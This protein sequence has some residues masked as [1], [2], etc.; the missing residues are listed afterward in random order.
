MSKPSRRASRRNRTRRTRSSAQQ[1]SVAVVTYPASIPGGVSLRKDVELVRAAILYADEVQLVSLG[2]VTLAGVLQLA[3]G[4]GTELLALLAS[5]DDATVE[6][7][8]GG[9]LPAGWRE[10][11]QAMP[12]L[13]SGP[14]L[15]ALG[16]G[17]EKR[18]FL[19]GMASSADQMR[20]T[21]ERMLRESGGEELLLGFDAGLVRLSASGFADD[22][23]DTDATLQRWLDLLKNLLS[24]T[25]SRLL[26][27]DQVAEL[28]RAMIAEGL[29]EPTD[30]VLKHASEAAV[31][32]GLVARLPAFPQA[33]LD[34]LLDLRRDLQDP[35]VRYRSAVTRLAADLRSRTYEA[36]TASELDDLWARE[37][38]PVLVELDESYAEHS[39]VREIARQLGT[40]LKTL[41]GAGAGIYV[42]LDKL[43][44]IS[45]WVGAAAAVAAPVAE[46]SARGAIASSRSRREASRHELFYLY[47]LDRHLG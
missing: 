8:G 12:A 39:L 16:L 15:D 26:F 17:A 25:R 47:E 44:T 14:V 3:S 29:V 32:S 28:V 27:D 22:D 6:A 23:G 19:E 4:D 45:Q 9:T 37:I 20:E 21:A 33:P 7:L 43:T 5:L 11:L 30:L 35:L 24:D 2:A 46:A 42:G 34:E 31:G 40:D 10:L 13:A 18:Q 36:G 38:A 1:L 41:I